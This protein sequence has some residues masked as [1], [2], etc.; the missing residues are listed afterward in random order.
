MRPGQQVAQGQ[1]IARSGMTGLATGPHLD[2][3]V[4]R[5]GQFLNFLH[6]KLPPAESVAKKDWDEFA[7][8]RT[9]LFDRLASLHNPPA[10]VSAQARAQPPAA[11]P[12]RN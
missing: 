5:H 7:A 1:L 10:T 3:R 12:T 4:E 2:F 11:A 8:M 9:R 6:L